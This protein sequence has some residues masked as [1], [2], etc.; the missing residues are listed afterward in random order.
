MTF[1]TLAEIP[2]IDARQDGPVEIARQ[3]ESRLHALFAQARRSYT[4]SML[5]LA[6]RVTR[7]WFERAGNPHADEMETIA[8]LVGASGAFALNGS[9]EWC[10]TS[11]VGDDPLGGVRLVRVLDWRQPG[12]GRN[13]VAARQRGSAGDYV[14]L[15]WPGFVGV[16]TAIAPGRFAAAINQ[17]PM[18]SWGLGLPLD[19]AVGRSKVWASRALPPAHLLRH[20]FETCADYDEAKRM[21]AQTPICLPAFF[22]LAGTRPGEG[23]VIERTPGRAGIRPMPAAIANHWV[24]LPERG[25]PRGR[26]SHGRHALLEA[27]LNG[28]ADWKAAPVI[29]RDTRMIALMNPSSGDLWVQGWERNAAATV[30]LE[31]NAA[32]IGG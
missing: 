1:A 6:D 9:Y 22:T 23:C 8:G 11:G 25:R 5:T 10:C 17:P 3:A 18:M 24:H 27:G 28:T 20:V 14:N 15:T 16:L 30:P 12:L 7:R 31:L 4:P 19:W 29:N 13:L 32:M 2:V 21:L 26:D